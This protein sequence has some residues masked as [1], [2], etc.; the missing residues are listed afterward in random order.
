M[1]KFYCVEIIRLTFELVQSLCGADG[2]FLVSIAWKIQ[3]LFRVGDTIA[4]TSSKQF[5]RN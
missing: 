4:T 5:A 3:K 1:E 2:V